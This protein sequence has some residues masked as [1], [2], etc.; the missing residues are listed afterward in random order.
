MSRPRRTRTRPSRFPPATACTAARARGAATTGRVWVS[1]E[2]EW[3]ERSHLAGYGQGQTGAR[4]EQLCQ[5]TYQQGSIAAM[6]SAADFE[7]LGVFYLGRPYDWQQKKAQDGLILYDS[8]DLVTHAVCVGHDRQRQDRP[9]PRAAR[10][11]GHR[12]HPGHRHRSQ[13]RSRQPAA[14]LPRAQA[15]G[16]PAVGQRGRRA[17][18]GPLGG[19]LRA[20]A[21]RAVAEGARGLGRGRRA[22]PAPARRG[23]LRDLHARQQRGH[24]AVDPEVVRGARRRPSARTRSCC[25]SASAPPRP[26]CSACS[27]ST[28]TRSR[29]ASTSC[30]PPSST[31]RGAR[32]RS[33]TWPASSSRSRRRR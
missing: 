10:R 28:P 33:S 14:H 27:A 25:A 23:R 15:G 18:E 16:L 5:P 20:P 1:T 12:R 26:A 9:V 29:A 4:C 3:A 21:G 2:E 31:P 7:K 30:S 19:R 32:G 24:P 13:G 17:P 11:G 22:H 8:K 6:P